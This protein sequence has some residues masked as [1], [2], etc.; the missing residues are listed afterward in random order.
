M[1]DG[2]TDMTKIPP[3]LKADVFLPGSRGIFYGGNSNGKFE[4]VRS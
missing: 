3:G 1:R 4:S 2:M